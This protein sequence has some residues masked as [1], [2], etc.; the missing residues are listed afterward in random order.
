[1][2]EN[3]IGTGGYFG[4]TNQSFPITPADGDY[5]TITY[6]DKYDTN[7]AP[8][9]Y[10]YTFEALSGQ[11]SATSVA[12][13]N[14]TGQTTGMLVRDM[15]SLS[16]LR[17][18]NYYDAKKRKVQAISQNHRTGT[19]RTSMVYDFP[20]KVLLTQRTY[21]AQTVTTTI[22]EAY[23][24]DH[25]ARPILLK[26]AIG[27]GPEVIV[28]KTIYN[29][30]GQ[31]IDKSLHST[32][33]GS[34]FKQSVDYRYNIRGWLTKINEADVSN[35][36]AGDATHDFFGMELLYNTGITGVTST[37]AFN[38]NISALQWSKG[39]AAKV[40]KQAYAF[41][42][43]RLNRL[44][45]ANH[46][47]FDLNLV[48]GL[49]SWTS[50]NNQYSE[51]LTYDYNGNIKTLQR[52]A[53]EGMLIDN[54]SYTYV[55]NMLSY[56]ND[57][58]DAT[59]GFVNANIGTDDYSYD[60]NGN[61]DKDKNKGLSAKGSIKYNFMNLPVEVVK[62]NEK[63]K[64]IYDASGR[65]M[66]QEVYNASG[67]LVKVTDYIGELVLE[68]TT[69]S[70]TT[71]KFV[72]H[73]EG[74]ICKNGSNWEY[75][76]HLKDHLGN[77]RVTFT[78][79]AQ[80]TTNYFTNFETESNSS[81][82][83]YSTNTFD[84]VDHTDAGTTYQKTQRLMG[85]NRVGVAK[86]FPVMPGDKIT[87]TAYVKYM[88]LTTTP[89]SATFINSLAGAFGVSSG[90]SGEALQAYNGLNNYAGLVS[91]GHLNDDDG[92]P[93]AF[94]TILF[95]DKNYKLIDAAWDQVSTVGEQTSPTVKGPHDLVTITAHAPDIGFA[96]VFVSNEHPNAVEVYFDDVTFSYTTSPIVSVSDY[97][98]FG[99][100]Y[101]N[102]EATGAFEQKHLYN[103]KELQDELSLNWYD[104]GARMY[105]PE[106]GR[107][108]VVD[109]MAE[110]YRRWSPYNYCMDNPV[111]F[112]DPD[113]MEVYHG[114]QAQSMFIVLRAQAKM[115]Q[116]NSKLYSTMDVEEDSGESTDKNGED[117]KSEK[118]EGQLEEE[119]HQT[120]GDPSKYGPLD[121][122]IDF[123]KNMLKGSSI[124]KD[125]PGFIIQ[126]RGNE[127]YAL[128]KLG[129]GKYGVWR[130]DDPNHVMNILSFTSVN[131]LLDAGFAAMGV[132][133]EDPRNAY[134]GPW[135]PSERIYIWKEITEENWNAWHPSENFPGPGH[136][137]YLYSDD[138]L[139][140]THS[141]GPDGTHIMTRT[142][143]K[144]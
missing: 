138:K 76:Y 6:Y 50:N 30:L 5:Y 125:W 106:I 131:G 8:V 115:N 9:G 130:I 27:S 74:R 87:A 41:T 69:A 61:L 107:W 112:I 137:R 44:T 3:Y 127:Q 136:Y 128:R 113:G 60:Y 10:T 102:G 100:Q 15:G 108:G 42:Y 68:G 11:E 77:V 133:D 35:I 82:L 32:D 71:T 40:T 129:K 73:A 34:T 21:V 120:Q 7:I 96:Y 78:T 86:S 55:G 13:V 51:V 123:W 70:N 17:T 53:A 31:P 132:W 103:G 38:G 52:K 134:I 28:S 49:R 20:G 25:S 144:Y 14:V 63:V 36:A 33:N 117:S 105:M 26:H 109:P 142:K 59:K 67:A 97:Y 75:Q 121:S 19:V 18:V 80:T 48:T 64:Y 116:M 79:K 2:F 119:N 1:M 62:G 135:L 95:F 90:S 47:D 72:Q 91:T 92:A 143:I 39:C 58:A 84:L 93:K 29:E 114:T 111:R 139:L 22:N 45:T 104:Y 94:V 118:R 110:K 85:T 12:S 46:S 141:R 89:N 37:N 99:M 81:F 24:Y 43:D 4:Y 122:Y 98:P 83:N 140:Y 88:N 126:G 124:P 23:T 101:N 65:K 66:S 16:M 56:V 54:L 57:G